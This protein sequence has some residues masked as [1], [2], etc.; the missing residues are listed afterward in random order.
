MLRRLSDVV[1]SASDLSRRVS[2]PVPDPLPGWSSCKAAAPGL[3]K[4]GRHCMSYR[5]HGINHLVR[6][7]P[8]GNASHCHIRTGDGMNSAHYIA[9]NA[10]YLHKTGYRIA[11][12]PKNPLD[13]QCHAV[14]D[15]LRITTLK[16]G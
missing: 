5:L 4:I 8:A 10:G 9:L 13:C 3:P 2:D 16:V 11:N 12:Q 15:R 6:R 7:N 14:A 1:K